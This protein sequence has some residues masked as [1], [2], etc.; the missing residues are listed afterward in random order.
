M[1]WAGGPL[2]ANMLIDTF[3]AVRRP[4]E[5]PSLDMYL[6]HDAHVPSDVQCLVASAVLPHTGRLGVALM[7]L[8]LGLLEAQVA[9]DP[10]TAEHH[11]DRVGQDLVRLARAHLAG[12]P[13]TLR[14][15]LIR[16][17]TRR[18]LVQSA[19]IQVAHEAT[20]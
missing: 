4:S 11:R 15:P 12:K 13:I 6:R 17:R 16:E 10:A 18:S 5:I 8:Q 2:I 7:P 19:E 3:H 1:S 14:P 20:A 9:R